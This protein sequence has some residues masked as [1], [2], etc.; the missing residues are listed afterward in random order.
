MWT[1]VPP[2]VVGF[3]TSLTLIAGL[4]ASVSH[5]GPCA[6]LPNPVVVTGAAAAE[7]LITNVARLL[8]R[9]D[10]QPL[11]VIWKLTTSCTGVESV[12]LD[13]TSSCSGSMG[14]CVYGQAKFWTLDP[15]DKEPKTCEL[16]SAG[17]HVDLAISDVMP[18]TCPSFPGAKLPDMMITAGPVTTYA[19]TMSRNASEAAMHASE[20]HFVFTRGKDANVR[21]WLNDNTLFLLGGNDAG[22]LL[23]SLRAS[24]KQPSSWRGK[25]LAS[26]DEVILNLQSDP[27]TA[28]GILPTTITD[29]RRGEVRTLAFQAIGQHGAY[30]PDRKSTTFDKQ[31]VRDGHYPLW[32]Y[33]HTVL[34]RDIANPTLPK[35]VNGGRLSEIL[36]G[37]AQV[38]MQD[39]M[40][41]HVAAGLVP[42]CAMRVSRSMDGGPMAPFAHADPCH[43]WFEKNVPGG[44]LGCTECPDGL[45]CAIGKC[46][47]KFCEV[48]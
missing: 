32:G 46:R 48:Q 38:A 6:G 41:M 7:P 20:A 8:Q 4:G 29:P 47:R 11:T 45:T 33:L 44:T 15:Q 31:N 23:V 9:N 14:A 27:P 28:I 30:F 42:Q 40:P 2:S 39:V 35:S 36:L 13:K 37:N 19:L 17:T 25:L 34:R 10:A 24:I 1:K 12:V 3:A 21:P 22:Q 18:S 43:C 26:P 16:D 5:A